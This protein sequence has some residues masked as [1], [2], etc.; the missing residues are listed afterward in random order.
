LI[1]IR[2][3]RACVLLIKNPYLTV[4]KVSELCGFKNLSNFN[5]KFKEIKLMSSKMIK[6]LKNIA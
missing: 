2:I 1:E 3:E 6:K 5:R 4:A